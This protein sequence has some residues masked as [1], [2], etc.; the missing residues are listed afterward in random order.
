M[1]E[2]SKDELLVKDTV[3]AAC[4]WFDGHKEE[5]LQDISQQIDAVLH[6]RTTGCFRV[7]IQRP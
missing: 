6:N 4:A 1:S 7:T 3:F 5:I 2:T